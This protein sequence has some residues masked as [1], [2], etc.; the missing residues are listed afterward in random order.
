METVLTGLDKIIGYI[1][2]LFVYRSEKRKERF[3]KFYA[4]MYRDFGVVHEEYLKLFDDLQSSLNQASWSPEF[5][6]EILS[7]IRRDFAK[8]REPYELK[9]L[10]IRQSARNLLRAVDDERERRFLWTVICYF[11]EHERPGKS[12]NQMDASIDLLTRKEAGN[13]VLRTP[14]SHMLDMLNDKSK[15]LDALIEAVD[16]FRNDLKGYLAD[17]VS[18]YKEVETKAYA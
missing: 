10:E 5:E 12:Y 1:R 9:R 15:D 6:D 18:T 11:L 16:T 17:I 3:E 13:A 14:S 4:Q 8:M 2:E 7:G